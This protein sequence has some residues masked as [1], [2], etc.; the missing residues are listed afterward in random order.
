MCGAQLPYLSEGLQILYAVVVIQ[1][2][3]CNASVNSVREERSLHTPQAKQEFDPRL[4]ARNI[5]AQMATCL[6]E[7]LFG[8]EDYLGLTLKCIVKDPGLRPDFNTIA[9]KLRRL[10]YAAEEADV[11]FR[12]TA[13]VPKLLPSSGAKVAHLRDNRG[14]IGSLSNCN[15]FNASLK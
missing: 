8:M 14:V 5:A 13:Y 15:F 12:H 3:L 7:T 1:D 9:A 4:Q 10:L 2:A 6:G 11:V